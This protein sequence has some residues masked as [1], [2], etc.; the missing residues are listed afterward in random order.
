MTT[1]RFLKEYLSD[2]ARITIKDID[3]D[4]LYVGDVISLPKSIIAGT[5]LGDIRLG[6]EDDFGSIVI[7]VFYEEEKSLM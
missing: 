3:G 6:S 7:T 2:F 1:K 4:V 5:I